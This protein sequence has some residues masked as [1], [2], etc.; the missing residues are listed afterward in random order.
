M[1]KL[2]LLTLVCL[3]A[4]AHNCLYAQS[5]CQTNEWPL[6]ALNADFGAAH[7]PPEPFDYTP[8]DKDAAMIT[9]KTL[10]AGKDGRA[11]YVPADE[12]ADNVL[13][14]FHEWWGLNDYIKLEAEKWKK[15]L[16]KT[17]VYAVDLYDG[18]VATDAKT[19][20]T[21]A[22]SLDKKRAETIIKGVLS[23]VGMD[24][25]VAT[26]GWCMGGSWSFTA[27]LLA[28]N[29]AA[30]CV[31]YYGFPEKDPKKI[32]ELQTDV[33]YMWA[34]KDKFI[35]ET[36]VTEFRQAVEATNHKITVHTFDADHA[37]ANP[38]NPK[39]DALAAAQA[40]KYVEDFLKE[41]LQVD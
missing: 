24:K 27:S 15:M 31:M 23:K 37:F 35:T 9:F 16:P 7:L 5:C 10:D 20:G 40:E 3:T 30:A 39:H 28:G 25:K 6:M 4:I 29:N 19:A 17:D 41:K 21:L 33:L 32:K 22:N 11:F 2:L 14:I 36:I 1:K 18:A 12:P 38:S 34:S 13:L 8:A 26:L